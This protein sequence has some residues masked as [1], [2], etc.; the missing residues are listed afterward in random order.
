MKTNITYALKTAVFALSLSLI[1]L[2]AAATDGEKDNTTATVSTS[3]VATATYT[4]RLNNEQN[5]HRAVDSV[6]VVLDKYDLTGAGVVMEVFYPDENNNITISNLPLGKYYA[7]IYVFGAERHHFSEVI[8]VRNSGLK[9]KLTNRINL[10][11]KEV[12]LY[13]P[14]TASLPAEQGSGFLYARR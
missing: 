14:G 12:E 1:N 7:E 11:L 9:K 6:L 4:I 5:N 8:A 13:V 3:N 2:V 10:K